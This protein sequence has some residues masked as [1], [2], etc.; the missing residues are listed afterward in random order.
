[1][2]NEENSEAEREPYEVWDGGER[3]RWNRIGL[4]FGDQERARD[5]MS[6]P[7]M[8]NQSGAVEGMKDDGLRP[9]GPSGLS[10]SEGTRAQGGQPS[11][12]PQRSGG[13]REILDIMSL[14]SPHK[15]RIQQSERWRT[16]MTEEI[17]ALEINQT[18]TLET[19]PPGKRPIDCKWVFKI[20]R[21][22]DGSVECYK[23]RLIAK[24]FTL[25]EGVDFHET[26]ALVAKLVTIRCLLIVAVTRRWEMHQ[27]DVQNAFLHG[28]LDEEVYIKLPPGFS[29]RRGGAV[30]RLRKSLY[31]L[32]Q[33]FRNWYSK[34]ADALR[35]YGFQQSGSSSTSLGCGH[36]SYSLSEAIS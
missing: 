15:T 9:S 22:A 21:R 8:K 11:S 36:E 28:N 6:S 24:G 32:R 18:W 30:C 35:G 10:R 34:F 31:G 20:K 13:P 19:L 12:Q 29:S 23:A 25:V 27:M 16:A 3:T 7:H 2:W 5:T 26:F 4:S 14:S 33:A 17:R 1:M